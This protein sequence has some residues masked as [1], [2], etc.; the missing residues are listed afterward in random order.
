MFND[1]FYSDSLDDALVVEQEQQHEHEHEQ[2][3][4]A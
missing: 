3:P 2:H 4:A 1:R